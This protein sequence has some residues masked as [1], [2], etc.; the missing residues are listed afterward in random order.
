MAWAAALSVSACGGQAATTSGETGSGG[1]TS[2][3][4]G[5]A[6]MGG[7]GGD[8][9]SGGSGGGIAADILDQIQATPGV[10]GVSEESSELQG[11]RYF[12]IDFDQPVDHD[13]PE[14]QHFTQ[15]IAL[16]HRD[17]KAP[18]VLAATGYYLFLPN[19]Y[20]EEPAALLEA[21]QLFVEQRYFY[22]SRPEPADWTL[23]D[24]AQA[25][26]DHHSIVE[27]FRPLY[28]GKWISTGAS[29]GGMTSVYHHRFYPKDV[30]GTV[31]YVAPHSA[32]LEDSRY[33]DF[34]NKVGTAACRQDLKD[35]EHEVLVRKTAML[36]R[37]ADQAAMNGLGYELLGIVPSFESTVISFSFAFWQYQDESLCSSIPGPG[38][39]DDEVWTFFD[40]VGYTLFSADPYVLG[41]EPYYWQAYTQ[42]GTPGV[43]T[44]HIDDLLTVDFSTVD[45]LPSIDLD[46]VFDPKAMQDISSWLTTEGS[47]ILFI[48]GQNDPWTS[49]EFEL[50]AATDSYKFVVPGGNHGSVIAGLLPSDQQT[51][52]GA[53]EAWTGVKPKVQAKVLPPTPL[54]PL[55]R[56][57]SRSTWH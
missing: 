50:G 31:A 52:L 22:P 40:S 29:K 18:M 27:A 19:Q 48:Y 35:F 16:H 4:T 1:A 15:R 32:G 54:P 33:V 2:D 7:A 38:A 8:T 25:A 51:A 14:G 43:D 55:F 57:R 46:P 28:S 23:L 53:L 56:V 9:G 47:R 5:A 11:Y 26:A 30:D 39:S 34:L 24:V 20:L 36:S 12:L 41:F 13:H 6:G 37:M 44:S 10:K 17:A 45:D 49:S 3:S 21:N 42:L